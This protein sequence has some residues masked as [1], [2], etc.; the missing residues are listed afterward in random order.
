MGIE[1]EEAYI[2]LRKS[3]DSF[4]DVVITDYTLFENEEERKKFADSVTEKIKAFI[5]NNA[6]ENSE[7]WGKVAESRAKAHSDHARALL[8]KEFSACPP[9]FKDVEGICVPITLL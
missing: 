5:R 2:S 9:G 8:A 4:K 7:M 6:I 1:N 3:L